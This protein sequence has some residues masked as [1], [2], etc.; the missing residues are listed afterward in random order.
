M[1]HVV[2]SVS[3]L[4]AGTAANV[5]PGTAE[6]RGTLR[7]LGSGDREIL[8]TRPAEVAALVAQAQGCSV[9]SLPSATNL[10]CSSAR[11]TSQPTSPASLFVPSDAGVTMVSTAAGYRLRAK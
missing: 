6:A 8:H 10:P 2:L 11:S 5:I 9:S 1:S 7:A 4:A 3:T